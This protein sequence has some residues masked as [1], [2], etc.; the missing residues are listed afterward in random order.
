MDAKEL[1]S[2]LNELRVKK[3][4][5]YSDLAELSGVSRA[6]ISNIEKGRQSKP[7]ADILSKIAPHLGVTKEHLM[8]VAGYLEKEDEAPNEGIENTDVDV[9]EIVDLYKVLSRPDL[10][11][12]YFDG[13]Q[14]SMYDRKQYIAMAYVLYQ[15]AR[16]WAKGAV[17]G[18]QPTD[19]EMEEIRR[20]DKERYNMSIELEREPTEQEKEMLEQLRIPYKVI[21]K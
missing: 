1:G 5:S 13:I 7:S 2:Y 20:L 10:Y 11:N 15:F 8:Q 6:Y 3:K 18:H 9:R 17:W 4:I 16:D 21:L 12:V 19:D 14:L